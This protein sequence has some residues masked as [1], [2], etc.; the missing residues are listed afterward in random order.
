MEV[1]NM[2]PSAV[3]CPACKQYMTIVESN[4]GGCSNGVRNSC[5]GLIYRC[6][7]EDSLVYGDMEKLYLDVDSGSMMLS[8]QCICLI[9]DGIYQSVP[10]VQRCLLGHKLRELYRKPIPSVSYSVYRSFNEYDTMSHRCEISSHFHLALIAAFCCADGY[11]VSKLSAA[12][13]EYGAAFDEF[14]SDREKFNEKHG[15]IVKIDDETDNGEP[16]NVVN[17]SKF[18]LTV[19]CL[20]KTTNCG[21][22]SGKFK[23]YCCFI[24][25]K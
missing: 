20:Q 8:D 10:G 17:V 12:F 13:P 15:F 4:R 2:D 18:V 11:N 9:C 16:L 21:S 7:G 5:H 24:N 14:T 1:D 23:S 3:Q 19:L 25:S 6:C 22:K